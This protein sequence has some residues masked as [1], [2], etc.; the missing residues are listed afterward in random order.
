MR[1]PIPAARKGVVRAIVVA[2]TLLFAGISPAQESAS[3]RMERVALSASG[4]AAESARF[5]TR[6]VLADPGPSGGMASACGTTWIQTTGF[7]SILAG[8]PVPIRLTVT[9]PSTDPLE[10][11][12]SWTGTD[13]LFD[14]R[15]SFDAGSIGDPAS[16]STTLAE[17]SATDPDP[18]ENEIIF[19]LVLPAGS[20][21]SRRS[22]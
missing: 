8:G 15:R 2:A 18:A 9:R 1:E 19:Y 14:V 5:E 12:L 10:V 11:E 6:I 13:A 22:R 20:D 3:F 21:P 16:V 17:C 7:L 4:G